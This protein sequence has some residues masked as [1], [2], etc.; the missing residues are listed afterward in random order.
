MVLALGCEAHNGWIRMFYSD[1]RP[2]IIFIIINALIQCSSI[3]VDANIVSHGRRADRTA[4]RNPVRVRTSSTI[5][6]STDFL[7]KFHIAGIVTDFPPQRLIP[8]NA[9]GY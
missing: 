7:G 8:L 4:W 3:T 1:E 2:Q 5:Y 9:Q 6:N